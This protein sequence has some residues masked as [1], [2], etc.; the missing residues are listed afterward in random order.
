MHARTVTRRDWEGGVKKKEKDE[1][2][3]E[4]ES[5]RR[6]KGVERRKS[7]QKGK[8]LGSLSLSVSLLLYPRRC[9]PRNKPENYSASVPFLVT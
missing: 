6:E 1:R 5:L 3:R 4:K 7:R 2:G 9:A 8:R